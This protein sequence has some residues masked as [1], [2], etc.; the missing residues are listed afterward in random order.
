MY[1]LLSLHPTY[2]LFPRTT[3]EEYISAGRRMDAL[4]FCTLVVSAAAAAAAAAADDDDDDMT[5]DSGIT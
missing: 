2:I 4:F 3:G 1:N 5:S